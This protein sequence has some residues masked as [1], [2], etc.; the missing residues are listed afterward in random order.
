MP[1]NRTDLRTDILTAF[2]EKVLELTNRREAADSNDR[3]AT[4]TRQWPEYA[5]KQHPVPTK[6][7]L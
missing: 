5:K 4:K 6:T 3:P 1:I 7:A 2:R